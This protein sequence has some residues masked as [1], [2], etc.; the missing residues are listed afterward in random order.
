MAI[1]AAKNAVNP[2]TIAII[3]KALGVNSK[4]G[5]NLINKKTPAVHNVNS[6]SSEL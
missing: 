2:P 5:D 3:N 6:T 4:I 1:D